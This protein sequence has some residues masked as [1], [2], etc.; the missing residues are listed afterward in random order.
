MA[1]QWLKLCAPT[2][3]NTG[4][5]PGW[6]TKICTMQPKYVCVCVCVCI[7]VCV[8]ICMYVYTYKTCMNEYYI[9]IN[10]CK[11]YLALF[12]PLNY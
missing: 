8:Y 4:S 11:F 5:I 6:G 1:I 7:Y 12:L 10:F 9:Y 2:A 3:R